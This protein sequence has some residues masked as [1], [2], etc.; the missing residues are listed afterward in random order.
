[1]APQAARARS[2]ALQTSV[3]ARPAVVAYRRVSKR[4]PRHTSWAV[5][6]VIASSAP[7][8]LFSSH[9]KSQHVVVA[10]SRPFVAAP[11]PSSAQERAS[12][13]DHGTQLQGGALSLTLAVP[14]R[15]DDLL[16]AE[17][18]RA[19]LHHQLQARVDA[20]RGLL[21]QS[22]AAQRRD[23]RRASGRITRASRGASQTGE[24]G[25]SDCDENGG[26]AATHEHD[27]GAVAQALSAACT[28]WRLQTLSAGP[29]GAV[30]AAQREPTRRR[31]VSVDSAVGTRVSPCAARAGPS[32]A[33]IDAYPAALQRTDFLDGI[34][35][36]QGSSPDTLLGL[37]APFV[38]LCGGAV[39]A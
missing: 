10:M 6:H 1:M 2:S 30:A 12:P 19:G 16:V 38:A 4:T 27:N 5:E 13:I 3:P 39:A 35:P 17:C 11:R 25:V 24:A 36:V 22:H 20:L 14:E 23:Q 37:W 28:A 29:H 33:R 32:W 34:V 9:S 7:R 8:K 18:H 21:L 31:V 15:A 26:C